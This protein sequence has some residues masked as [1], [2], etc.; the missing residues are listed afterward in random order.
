[1]VRP[2]RKRARLALLLVLPLLALAAAC[3]GDD[4]DDATGTPLPS[5][6]VSGSAT[7][8]PAS[9][10]DQEAIQESFRA[11]G[12]SVTFVSTALPANWPAGFPQYEGSSLLGEVEPAA[13][14]ASQ[15]VVFVTPDTLDEVLN[16]FETTL[17][18]AGFQALRTSGGSQGGSVQFASEDVN[19]AIVAVQLEGRTA[20]LVR[21]A[22]MQ[23]QRPGY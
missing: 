16:W 1:M 11:L 4:D 17:N 13:V 23:A 8:G 19:G 3:G 7:A 20:I 2:V 18:G 14:G 9:D 6:T 15:A 21:Y 12:L 10:A 22:E 5:P